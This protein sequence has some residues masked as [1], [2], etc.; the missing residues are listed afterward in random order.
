MISVLCLMIWVYDMGR[1]QEMAEIYGTSQVTDIAPS[2]P[3][4]HT[5]DLIGTD[6]HVAMVTMLKTYNTTPYHS[7]NHQLNSTYHQTINHQTITGNRLVNFPVIYAPAKL[8]QSG[9]GSAM[10]LHVAIST[11]YQGQ[12]KRGNEKCT[13]DE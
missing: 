12:V 13:P 8:C 6:V 5:R 2:I 1:W 11:N 10:C 3:Y 4:I 7:I 9:S